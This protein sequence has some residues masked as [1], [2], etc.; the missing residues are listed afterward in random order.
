METDRPTSWIN[1]FCSRKR[2][3]YYVEVAESFIEDPFNLIGLSMHISMYKETLEV[4]LDLEPDDAMYNRV[5]D[6][7]LLEPSA[8]LL[9][10]LIHQRYILTK[11]GML[12][13]FE[14]YITGDFGKCPRVYCNDHYLLPCGQHDLPKQS[15]VRLY[16]PN[17]KDIYIP[18]NPKHHSIDGA[19][20]GTTFP[21]L[22][23]QAFPECIKYVEPSIYMPKIF[24]FRVSELSDV[25]PRMQWLRMITEEQDSENRHL[26]TDED[27]FE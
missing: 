22:F 25:G 5:P 11:E 15:S 2:N 19:H 9:Y 27:E 14:K 10:G 26:L 20:F 16:C 4:I 6:L 8:E 12:S 7:S 18:A 13:M 17:C 24:G 21:H 3:K 23:V 1:W